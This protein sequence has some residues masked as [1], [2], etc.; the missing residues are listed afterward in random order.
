MPEIYFNEIDQMSARSQ[1]SRDDD[2]DFHDFSPYVLP[3]R[4]LGILCFAKP[5]ESEICN[6][7][8]N[9]LQ[10]FDIIRINKQTNKQ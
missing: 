6:K 1:I 9:V 10:Y 7:F 5:A 3:S 4:F 8:K 2:D